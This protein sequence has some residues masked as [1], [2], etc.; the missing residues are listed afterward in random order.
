MAITAAGNTIQLT[1]TNAATALWPDLREIVGMS[2]EGTGLTTGQELVVR[3]GAT[4]GSG[5]VL[6]DYITEGTTDQRDLW[7]E[8]EP[9]AVRGIAL[10]NTTIDGTWTLT[11]MFRV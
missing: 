10:D 4:I 5:D 8:R 3:A 9:M 2:F 7:N 11:V 6:A 1:A